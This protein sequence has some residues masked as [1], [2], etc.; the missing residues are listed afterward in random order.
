MDMLAN[1]SQRA[2]QGFPCRV[3]V[4]RFRQQRESCFKGR[5]LSLRVHGR[6]SQAVD[7]HGA[8]SDITEFDENLRRDVEHLTAPVQFQHGPSSNSM[9]RIRRIREASEDAGVDEI[10]H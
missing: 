8:G 6:K 1:D 9:L 10:S 4:R 7:R 3:D 5:R 2:D